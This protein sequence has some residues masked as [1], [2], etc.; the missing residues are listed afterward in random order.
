[1][2]KSLFYIPFICGPDRELRQMKKVNKHFE[3]QLDIRSFVRVRTNLKILLGLLYSDEQ[4]MLFRAQRRRSVTLG[5]KG[6][7]SSSSMGQTSD[8]LGND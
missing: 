3:D 8:E 5:I 4:I 1:M 2:C 6:E 7:I